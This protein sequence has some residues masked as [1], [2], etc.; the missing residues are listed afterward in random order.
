MSKD[1]A[2]LFYSS[3]FL[4]GTMFMSD[5]QVGKY[6]RLLCAQH[7]KGKLS[8]SDMMKICKRHDED[9]F[10][11]FEVDQHGFYFNSRLSEE[12]VRRKNYSISRRNNRLK[13]ES[14][15]ICKTYD[16]HMETEAETENLLSNTK[17]ISKE[18][19]EFI[20]E[21]DIVSINNRNGKI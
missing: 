10:S 13:K 5:A 19:E 4:T 20:K 6:I 9:I 2:F 3:D 12:M 8:K 1:P 17:Q 21:F 18:D 7:Q 14:D 16:G 11:H 15:K